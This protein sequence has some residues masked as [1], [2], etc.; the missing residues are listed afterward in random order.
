M[1]AHTHKP[2]FAP[3]SIL[4]PVSRCMWFLE[5][6]LTG[7]IPSTFTGLLSLT[8]LNL[9]YNSLTGTIPSFL[10]NLLPGLANLYLHENNLTGS[11]PA[12][13]GNL[14]LVNL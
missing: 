2:L 3:C 7:S 8:N 13:L 9:G 11:I 5:N 14:D 1:H 6:K 12:S 10:G 4:H